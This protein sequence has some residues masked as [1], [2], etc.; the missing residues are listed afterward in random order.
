MDGSPFRCLSC[1]YVTSKHDVEGTAPGGTVATCPKCGRDMYRSTASGSSAE[2]QTIVAGGAR[3]MPA[4]PSRYGGGVSGSIDPG[5]YY[6]EEDDANPVI[7]PHTP[8]VVILGFIFAI[9]F[10][11]AGLVISIVAFRLV[12]DSPPNIRGKGLAIAGIAVG[13]VMTVLFLMA[14]KGML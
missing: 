7:L 11:P 13:A 14:L 6:D 5:G 8:F 3:A 12:N 10:P 1:G 4:I 2:G 9:I